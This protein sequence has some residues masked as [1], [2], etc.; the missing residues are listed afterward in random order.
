ML[1]VTD[2]SAKLWVDCQPVHSVQGYLESP[3][4][5]RGHYDTQDGFLS[6]AQNANARRSYQVRIAAVA[7][8]M[9]VFE[10][11]INFHFCFFFSLVSTSCE[12]T[13]P[14]KDG[15]EFLL[16]CPRWGGKFLAHI[17]LAIFLPP[18]SSQHD[19]IF[20]SLSTSFY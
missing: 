19:V 14:T 2:S 18:L 16:F 3:L 20:A 12:Y 15:K 17:D 1:G 6:I 13:M 4:K 5:E 9:T 7:F 10:Q 11:M 8:M